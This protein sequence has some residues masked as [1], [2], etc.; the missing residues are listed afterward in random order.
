[1]DLLY[2]LALLVLNAAG[3]F[4]VALT[5]PGTWLILLATAGYVW[6]LGDS[7][8]GFGWGVLVALLALAVLG[9]ILEL[10]TSAFGV[11]SAGG[12]RRASFGAI[13]GGMVG[14]IAGTF[15]LPVPVVGSI[16]GAALGSFLGALLAERSRG[17]DLRRQVA[18]GKGAF[19]GR[20]FGTVAKLLVAAIMWIVVALAALL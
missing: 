16:L 10:I 20:L 6:L 18:V 1:M 17:S 2:L 9:E 12:S 4:I 14:A 8:A 13:A 3:V 11:Q 15:L 7:R 19:W 5:L